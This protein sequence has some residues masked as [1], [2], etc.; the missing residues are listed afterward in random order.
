[1]ETDQKWATPVAVSEKEN[2]FLFLKD[3]PIVKPKLVTINQVVLTGETVA[4]E[5]WGI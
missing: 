1:M 5:R 4:W 2:G 3:V